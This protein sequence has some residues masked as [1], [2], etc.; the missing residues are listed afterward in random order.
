MCMNSVPC[1]LSTCS[2]MTSLYLL[3]V[4]CIILVCMYAYIVRWNADRIIAQGILL[5]SY[6][7]SSAFEVYATDCFHG[8]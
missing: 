8:N 3:S 7:I 4:R 6:V 2:C 1:L 5:G